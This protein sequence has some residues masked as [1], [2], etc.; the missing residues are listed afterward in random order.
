MVV[1][2]EEEL[3]RTNRMAAR[4]VSSTRRTPRRRT[5]ARVA[6]AVVAFGLVTVLWAL[7]WVP[8]APL[9]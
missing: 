3:R 5:L 6:V 7:L 4:E 8:L 1:I 9:P 2:L